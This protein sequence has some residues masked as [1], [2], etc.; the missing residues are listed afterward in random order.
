M[1]KFKNKN[2]IFYFLIL[3]CTFMFLLL[4][5][6]TT[7]PLCLVAGYDSAFFKLVG[8]A[9]LNG[10]LPYRD[11]F[12]MKG[13]YLFLVEFLG[14]MICYG[15]VGIFILQWINLSLT[16]FIILRIYDLYGVKGNVSK[17]LLLIPFFC[18][19]N[20][21]I[22][23]GNLTEEW[24]LFPLFLCLYYSLKYF[25]NIKEDINYSHN[26]KWAFLYGIGFGYIA[27]IRITNTALICSIVLCIC[28]ILIK[29]KEYRNLWNNAL[30]F[31]GG[32]TLISLPI[33]LFYLNA[34]LL[35]EMLYSVFVFGFKYSSEKGI[36]QHIA[37]LRKSF[38]GLYIIAPLISIF[39]KKNSRMIL[40]SSVSAISIMCSLITGNNYTHYYML[41]LPLIILAEVELAETDKKTTPFKVAVCFVIAATVLAVVRNLMNIHMVNPDTLWFKQDSYI[42]KVNATD[43]VD[44]IPEE[45][46]DSVFTYDV[47]LYW[48]EYTDVFPCIKYCGWQSHYIELVPSIEYELIDI[49]EEKTPKWIVLPV[50]DINIPEYLKEEFDKFDCIYTNDEYKLLKYEGICGSNE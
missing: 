47:N 44:H 1:I 9:M 50:E 14:Q 48:Y 3:L 26:P 2:L 49:I 42:E 17:V 39:F 30:C 33:I 43:I 12:D 7:S 41:L 27:L 28:I 24:S 5:S 8:K 20:I 13:P 19:L 38:C 10:K 25:K 36:F 29:Y 23:G 6:I 16:T 18:I 15:R 4:F 37:E 22:E 40:F 21:T 31:F 32:V 34:G 46:R 35:K 45:D 11:F